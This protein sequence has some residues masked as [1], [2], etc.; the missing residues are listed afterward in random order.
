METIHTTLE[1]KIHMLIVWLQHLVREDRQT[2]RTKH[3]ISGDILAVAMFQCPL[4]V[5]AD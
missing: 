2:D 5:C 4:A 1:L 3:P